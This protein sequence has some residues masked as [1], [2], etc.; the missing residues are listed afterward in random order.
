MSIV[1]EI[2]K[3][4]IYT[5][6]LD[7]DPP[8]TPLKQIPRPQA[9]GSTSASLGSRYI[10]R[11][12]SE[13]AIRITRGDLGSPELAG[14]PDSPNTPHDE[15]GSLLS[16]T[17]LTYGALTVKTE[18]TDAS[19]AVNSPAN[20]QGPSNPTGTSLSVGGSESLVPKPLGSGFTP[21]AT[22]AG[23]PKNGF[24]EFGPQSVPTTPGSNGS[25]Y[26]FQ[27]PKPQKCSSCCNCVIL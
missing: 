1:E 18:L 22:D 27:P 21:L 3:S 5:K 7:T 16:R 26:T 9:P 15:E 8:K 24:I 4:A 17:N 23:S 6:P 25:A 19:S 10:S 2:L 12:P 11:R 14:I 20:A 13:V